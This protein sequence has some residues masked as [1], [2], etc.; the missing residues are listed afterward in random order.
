MLSSILEKVKLQFHKPGDQ[1]NGG[2]LDK[3]GRICGVGL[4]SKRCNGLERRRCS[5]GLGNR[6][7]NGG[8]WSDIQIQSYARWDLSLFVSF[9]KCFNYLL[10]VELLCK[11]ILISKNL[12]LYL[13][14]LLS[15]LCSERGEIHQN[16]LI[17]TNKNV[18]FGLSLSAPNKHI[19]EP[20]SNCVA[21]SSFLPPLFDVCSK[22]SGW[23]GFRRIKCPDTLSLQAGSYLGSLCDNKFSKNSGNYFKSL[24][25]CCQVSTVLRFSNFFN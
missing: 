19:K 1:F 23:D 21:Y 5:I 2:Q 16:T 22:I 10:S 6:R 15:G 17:K 24:V 18:L 12:N 25:N 11:Y 8:S 20:R 14:H 7:C 4:R 13:I 3:R 9:F